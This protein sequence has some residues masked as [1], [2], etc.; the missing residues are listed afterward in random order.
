MG[1]GRGAKGSKPPR[2]ALSYDNADDD[3]GAFE[4]APRVSHA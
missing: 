3:D 1:K 4:Q 2:G